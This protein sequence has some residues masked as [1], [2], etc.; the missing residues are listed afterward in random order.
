MQKFGRAK[1][2]SFGGLLILLAGIGLFAPAPGIS[3]TSVTLG[4]SASAGTNIA[5]Y[6]LYYG[7]AAGNYNRKLFLGN[8]TTARVTDLVEGAVYYFAVTASSFAGQES[9]P[10]NEV[11]YRVPGVAVALTPTSADP[12]LRAFALQSRAPRPAAAW[13][14]EA[15]E[16]LHTWRE[17]AGG[18]EA[19]VQVVI[20]VSSDRKMPVRLVSQDPGKSLQSKKVSVK[21]FPQ[22]IN[23][24][25]KKAAPVPWKLEGQVRSRTWSTLATGTDL[26]VHVAIVSPVASA[27]FFR[28]KSR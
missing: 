5:G 15:S 12:A 25:A 23:F 7:T 11:A 4:W 9:P 3:D 8:V 19:T 18:S 17:V 26:P 16:D 13:I 21:G 10:S 24:S 2:K 14:L 6:N 28:L 27:M 1:I 22:T 20:V